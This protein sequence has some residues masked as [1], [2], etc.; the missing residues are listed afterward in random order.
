MRFASLEIAV[1]AAID[2]V[3]PHWSTLI[4]ATIGK[5]EVAPFLLSFQLSTPQHNSVGKIATATGNLGRNEVMTS[6][7][8]YA[9]MKTTSRR[10]ESLIIEK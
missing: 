3:Y 9:A 5:C 2:N 4:P 8:F 7:D 6:L 10:D 1:I